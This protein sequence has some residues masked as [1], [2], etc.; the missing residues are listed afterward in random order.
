METF[1]RLDKYFYIEPKTSRIEGN[2]I[3]TLLY[4]INKL[5][6]F[7]EQS[8]TYTEQIIFEIDESFAT[9]LYE[10]YSL[11]IRY[12]QRLQKLFKKLEEFTEFYA[13]DLPDLHLI[14]VEK[15]RKIEKF[16]LEIKKGLKTTINKSEY[17]KTDLYVPLKVNH[18]LD[19][20]WELLRQS[21]FEEGFEGS[22]RAETEVFKFDEDLPG[23]ESFGMI[24]SDRG[25]RYGGN[26]SFDGGDLARIA[27]NGLGTVRNSWGGFEGNIGKGGKKRGR[28]ELVK[29]SKVFGKRMKSVGGSE[30]ELGMMMKK[31][32]PEVVKLD[33]GDDGS[34]EGVSEGGKEQAKAKRLE[35]GGLE[36][37]KPGVDA[38]EEIF[39][40]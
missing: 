8:T 33:V 22:R 38:K 36:V 37:A 9:C 20:N 39:E 10:Q 17:D 19:T 27:R 34:E 6:S 24:E 23:D 21:F 18:T 11:F 40:I 25:G 29:R 12:T 35:K 15:N 26:A 14:D 2:M 16:M 4:D 7:L 30:S 3:G 28:R 31:G 1:V 13:L 5:Y 32:A